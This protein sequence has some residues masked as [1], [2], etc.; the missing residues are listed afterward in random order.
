MDKC[1][2]CGAKN[3]LVEDTKDGQVLCRRCANFK[4]FKEMVDE[5]NEDAIKLMSI[6][7]RYYPDNVEKQ[8]DFLCAIF[9]LIDMGERTPEGGVS[10]TTKQLVEVAE[11]WHVQEA[12]MGEAVT[13]LLE[14]MLSFGA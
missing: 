14:H 10:V 9:E 13:A 7:K 3:D 4:I 8:K 5:G 2:I 6:I 12:L 11:K 1:E